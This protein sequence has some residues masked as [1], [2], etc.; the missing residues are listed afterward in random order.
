MRDQSDRQRMGPPIATAV[1]MDKPP[2]SLVRDDKIDSGSV[3]TATTD[4]CCR[5]ILPDVEKYSWSVKAKRGRRRLRGKD[6]KIGYQQQTHPHQLQNSHGEEDDQDLLKK[7]KRLDELE[8]DDDNTDFTSIT[9]KKQRIDEGEVE[10]I[11]M[12]LDK[13]EQEE[14]TSVR[15]RPEL[16]EKEVVNMVS[17]AGNYK[18]DAIESTRIETSNSNHGMLSHDA[19]GTELPLKSK[20][21]SVCEGTSMFGLKQKKKAVSSCESQHTCTTC[22]KSFSSHQ[23]LG[24]HRSSHCIKK[25]KDG[26]AVMEEG[27]QSVIVANSRPKVGNHRC[28]Q[29]DK[30]FPTGQALG[31]HKRCHFNGSMMIGAPISS[32][33]S[34]ATI[35]ENGF[36]GIGPVKE[37]NFSN[38]SFPRH[39]ALG[40]HDAHQSVASVLNEPPTP[41]TSSQAT[42]QEHNLSETGNGKEIDLYC[43]EPFQIDQ[44]LRTHNNVALS[45][46]A[47]KLLTSATTSQA[48][49]EENV[50][51]QADDRGIALAFDLNEMPVMEGEGNNLGTPTDASCSYRH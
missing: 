51:S 50:H 19:L 42:T 22:N 30:S 31:G 18:D 49:T 9:S 45:P 27:S 15:S 44:A 41:A 26:A 20:A 33:S 12:E 23:A 40:G 4:F 38:K 21:Y 32:I 37:F 43:H 10:Y 39:Q 3:D 48:T 7:R 1:I 35:A 2:P 34:L 6:H 29:C 24:G 16:D 28:N 8:T 11:K 17:S 46:K 47:I 25:V 13:V 36:S 14:A 5:P